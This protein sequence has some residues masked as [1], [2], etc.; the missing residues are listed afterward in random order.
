MEKEELTKII[1]GWIFFIIIIIVIFF[2]FV[3]NQAIKGSK[4]YR[5]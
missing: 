4:G 2:P 3:K 1:N 5:M